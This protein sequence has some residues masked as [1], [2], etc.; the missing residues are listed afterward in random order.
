[1]SKSLY[2]LFNNDNPD[3][4]LCVDLKNIFFKALKESLMNPATLGHPNY[5]IPFFFSFWIRRRRECPLGT[6]PK[7]WGPL[8]TR[9]VLKVVTG[10][11]GMGITSLH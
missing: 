1:M 8:S 5:Q 10:P 3:L 6:H 4:I 9:K 11:C 2:I 7:S